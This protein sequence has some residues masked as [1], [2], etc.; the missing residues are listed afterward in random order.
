MESGSVQ[1]AKV[2]FKQNAHNI[3]FLAKT[4][5]QMDTHSKHWSGKGKCIN[6]K[7]FKVTIHSL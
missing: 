5:E 7:Y 1:F 2:Q 3:S 6:L 4:S